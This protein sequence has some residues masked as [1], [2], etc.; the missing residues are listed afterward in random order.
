VG[1]LGLESSSLSQPLRRGLRDFSEVPGWKPAD[2]VE[3]AFAIASA[4]GG[5]LPFDILAYTWQLAGRDVARSQ[6][7]SLATD[8][9]L[10]AFVLCAQY[11]SSKT[12]LASLRLAPHA[13]AL[14]TAFAFSKEED[15]QLPSFAFAKDLEREA[16]VRGLRLALPAALPS[17]DVAELF[18]VRGTP[19]VA[20]FA[21][22]R[23]QT[24]LLVPREKHRAK[25]VGKQL[26][27]FGRLMES[28]LQAMGWRTCWAWPEDWQSLQQPSGDAVEALRAAIE[29]NAEEPLPDAADETKTDAADAEGSEEPEPRAL[30]AEASPAVKPSSEEVPSKEAEPQAAEPQEGSHEKAIEAQPQAMDTGPAK[31]TDAS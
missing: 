17:E 6:E 21:F 27:G 12:V 23:L 18:Q 8:P 31:A 25:G 7:E 2:T 5:K 22:E 20:D 19:Y 15:V 13:P 28:T 30:E 10:W 3:L 24:L 9:K 4:Y 11:L 29:G 1:I 14:D 16:L 26:S